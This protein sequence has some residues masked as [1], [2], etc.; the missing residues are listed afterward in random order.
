MK[1]DLPSVAILSLVVMCSLQTSSFAEGPKLNIKERIGIFDS[2]AVAIAYGNSAFLAKIQD[3]QK[4]YQQAKE[5]GDKKEAA[6]L[7]AIELSLQ[8]QI[9]MQAFSTAPV[10]D[11]LLLISADLPKIQK[12]ASV[13][14]LVSKWDKAQLKKHLNAEQVDVTMQ[15]VNA[16]HLKENQKEGINEIQKLQPIPLTHAAKMKGLRTTA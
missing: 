14:C 4:R 15:L 2:R 1:A 13:T 8:S 6:R 11:I 12:T 5:H 9:H 16:F 3:L 10:D 7:K